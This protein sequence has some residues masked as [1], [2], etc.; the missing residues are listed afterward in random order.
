MSVYDGNE[1]KAMA[2]MLLQEKYGLSQ[3]DVL[4]NADE[5]L[6]PHAWK[7]LEE[8]VGRLCHREPIQYVLGYTFFCDLKIMVNPDV[9]IPRP[10][11]EELIRKIGREWDEKHESPHSILDIGTGSGCIALSFKQAYPCSH[12]EAVDLSERALKVA[13]ANAERLGLDVGFECKDI[14]HVQKETCRFDLIVSNPPYICESEREEMEQNV[15]DYE[16]S[17]ALF[18]PN[19]DPLLFYRAIIDYSMMTLLPG[20]MLA[21]ET[22]R[23]YAHDVAKLLVCAGFSSVMIEKDISNNDRMVIG[24][25]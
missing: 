1:S 15:L 7:E 23:L 17:M 21:M 9:L 14:L 24:W 2:L 6:L 20:G 16:P 22:N 4:M 3:K 12:V 18:V 19:D 8:I 10:E 25:L 5:R 13:R 11:T